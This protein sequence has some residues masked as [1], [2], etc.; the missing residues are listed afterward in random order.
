MFSFFFLSLDKLNVLESATSDNDIPPSVMEQD[1]I[2]DQLFDLNI[3]SSETKLDEN[4]IDEERDASSSKSEEK[5]DKDYLI[6]QEKTRS[7]VTTTTMKALSDTDEENERN[8]RETWSEE[9]ENEPKGKTLI[10]Q[11]STKVVTEETSLESSTEN[12][13]SKKDRALN[14]HVN[15]DSSEKTREGKRNKRTK[16]PIS[17]QRR[18]IDDRDAS[19]SAYDK[20]A[21]NL[22]STKSRA[23]A[24]NSEEKN[25]RLIERSRLRCDHIVE[26]VYI[27]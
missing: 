9:H 4:F 19:V 1:E 6:S 11:V 10:K 8:A 24:L 17:S 12:V 15:A 27:C 2:S 20:S 21:T 7:V 26:I 5:P 23:S 16:T 3:N 25:G 18:S 13:E 14:G 22:S